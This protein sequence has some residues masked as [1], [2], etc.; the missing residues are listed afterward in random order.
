MFLEG[1]EWQHNFLYLDVHEPTRQQ[2]R[3]R[4]GMQRGPACVRAEGVCRRGGGPCPTPTRLHGPGKQSGFE[5][6]ISAT[7]ANTRIG[8]APSPA[9]ASRPQ[10][11]L[12]RPEPTLPPARI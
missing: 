2:V 11:V 1:G 6:R 7:N 10:V 3:G 5:G 4:P 8:C 9:P 12:V